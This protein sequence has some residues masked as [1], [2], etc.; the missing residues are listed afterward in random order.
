MNE[1]KE[2]AE[3]LRRIAQILAKELE[4]ADAPYMKTLIDGYPNSSYVMR[5][6]CEE[7]R[8]LSRLLKNN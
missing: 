6:S 1:V 3:K 7:A 5:V 8:E 2:A 4:R